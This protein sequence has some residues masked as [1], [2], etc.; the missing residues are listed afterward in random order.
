[1]WAIY[2]LLSAFFAASCDPIAKRLLV[3][4]D[5]DEYLIGWAG[6]LLSIPFL[7][8]FYFSHPVAPLNPGLVKMLAVIVPLEILALV[9]YYRALKLTDIS[10]SVPF[11]ALTP[12]F[13]I[14]TA[15]L[16]LGERLPPHGILGILLITTGVYSL[17]L[18]E[19][20][21]GIFH[22]IKA[23]LS[24]KGSVYMIVVALIFS[25]NSAISKIAMLY[26]SPESIPFIYNLSITLVMAPL[27]FYR[28]KKGRSV[29]SKDPR[30]ILSYIAIGLF[31]ALSSICYFQSIALT[32]VAYTIS[33][34]RLSLLMSVG[35]GWFFF[36]ERDI[37]IRLVGTFCMFL[38]VVLIF[39]S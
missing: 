25:L 38:G 32:N 5:G 4:R 34:K 23:V 27:V 12:I 21:S 29:L 28:L 2:A 18:N 22:P 14:L 8:I 11:L 26:S 35:C 24:N 20:K 6:P 37:R 15:F 19:I 30:T 3:L 10:L 39:L 16:L 33:I 31:A 36:R 7:A 13:V 1:M 17:N 9:L